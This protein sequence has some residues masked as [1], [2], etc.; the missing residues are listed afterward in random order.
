MGS[1]DPE[2][3]RA[4]SAVGIQERLETPGVTTAHCEGHE[5][6][7]EPIAHCGT[8]TVSGL[9]RVE[10]VALALALRTLLIAN[11]SGGGACA[12]GVIPP[13]RDGGDGDAGGVTPPILYLVELGVLVSLPAFEVDCP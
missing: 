11:T 6:E 9:A 5:G 7:S 13:V 8:G 4:H 2:G 1:V 10:F 3:P 12:G